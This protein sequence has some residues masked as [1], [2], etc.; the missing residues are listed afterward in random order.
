M[1][2]RVAIVGA[3]R[4]GQ[5]LAL[6]LQRGGRPVALVSRTAH[7]VADP[8]ELHPGDRADALR[9]SGVALLAVPD[10]AIAPLADELAADG[11]IA[12]GHVVL[13]LSGL[14]DRAALAPLASTG[15][16][17]GSFHPLQTVS[18]PASAP[19]R[20]R[21]AYAGIEGDD[22]AL[23]AGRDLAAV[24]GMTPVT[25][26]PMA[27]PAYHAGASV[28]AN[29]T[30]V[31]AAVAERLA[32]TAGVPPDVSRRLY[33]PLIRGAAANLD[34]GPAAALTG[35]VRRG[36]ADTVAAHLR[37]LAPPDRALY[38]LLAREALRLAEE[39]GLRP[40]AA[41][42]VRGVLGAATRG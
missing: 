13:H 33:L 1:R 10:R 30:V 27:K 20:L 24:L 26:P 34:A 41:E 9:E 39:A 23:A 7:P 2:A 42:R 17:L 15:A 11:V 25:I 16:A 6:A 22:R 37:T 35:P 32:V 28:A 5:G 29:F 4:M 40:E 19:D 18:D 3:G 12:A 8:L 21:G 31:L 36:D 14:L 38:I